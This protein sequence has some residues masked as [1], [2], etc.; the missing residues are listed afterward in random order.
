MSD[1]LWFFLANETF[2][3]RGEG[4]QQDWSFHLLAANQRLGAPLTRSLPFS[5]QLRVGNQ[6][7]GYQVFAGDLLYNP[8]TLWNEVHSLNADLQGQ[9]PSTT[10]L[11]YQLL[12]H[13]YRRCIT[14]GNPSAGINT[15]IEFERRWS[16]HQEAI[17]SNLG[18]ALSG[19]YVISPFTNM[20][21]MLQ[22]FAGDTLYSSIPPYQDTQRLSDL[23]PADPLFHSL[24]FETYKV[25]QAIFGNETFGFNPYFHEVAH[26]VKLGAPLSDYYRVSHDNTPYDLQ[27]FA[28]DTLYAT[29]GGPILR[30]SDLPLPAVVQNFRLPAVGPIN[31]GIVGTGDGRVPGTGLTSLWLTNNPMTPEPI[32]KL[33]IL[34]L[35]VLGNVMDSSVLPILTIAQ[36][37]QMRSDTDIVCADLVSMCL[38]TAGVNMAWTVNQPPGTRYTSDRAANYYRPHQGHMDLRQL[39]D[40]DP[41]LPGDILV[42]KDFSQ[43]IS[44]WLADEYHHVVIYTGPF[45]G[46]DKQGR[47]YPE[48][49]GYSVVS[50]S[51]SDSKTNGAKQINAARAS[52][53]GYGTVIR[54]RHLQIEQMYRDAGMIA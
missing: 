16:F 12:R 53:F 22:V 3:Q 34:A 30:W 13:A 4:F 28:Q 25:S 43:H 26:T 10:A 35:R 21:V 47:L 6:T 39:D 11:S 15:N 19:S 17:R 18:M 27:V 36:R 45:S 2:R 9:V 7:Y 24:W 32:R 31:G 54:M 33:I 46:S 5:Q 8:S 37:A 23:T 42:Y 48:T 44:G 20:L 38:K 50:S 41:W 49:A 14:A 52:Y 29:L 1:D 51:I 40:N